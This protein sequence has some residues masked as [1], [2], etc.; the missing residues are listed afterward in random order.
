[1]AVVL[2]G[3]SRMNKT[4]ESAMPDLKAYIDT[5]STMIGLPIPDSS[6][7]IVVANLEVA[8]RM[9]ALLDDFSLD[10]REEPALVYRP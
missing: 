9:A 4:N 5:V 6:K 2:R 3:S 7:P 1:M 8:M 10:E